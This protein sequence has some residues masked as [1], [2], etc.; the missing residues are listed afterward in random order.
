MFV[1]AA[2]LPW[3][4]E[5]ALQVSHFDE[6]MELHLPLPMVLYDCVYTTLTQK[7]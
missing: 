2:L 4:T 7:R 6:N 5:G 1:R 3:K